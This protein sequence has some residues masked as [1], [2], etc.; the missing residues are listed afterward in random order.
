MSFPLL[1]VLIA[2]APNLILVLFGPQWHGAVLP[3][4][5]LC[6]AGAFKVLNTY[7]SSA[8]QAAGRVWSEVWRQIGY[9]VLI[10]SGV[11][12]FRSWGPSGA[13]FG[14]LLATF[15]MSIMMHV[16]LRR[17]T[18]LRLA[19]LSR[20]LTPS[21]A[22]AMSVV[23]V[24]LVV[25]AGFRRLT[26][27]PNPWVVVLCQAVLALVSY[28]AFLLFVPSAPV[29]ALVHDVVSDM[30]PPALRERTWLRLYLQSPPPSAPVA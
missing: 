10:A 17:V 2:T 15:M 8:T 19:Q 11:Y 21:V 4:Q 7:A 6:V 20:A 29:R 27:D 16:L 30:V 1:A 24:V 14:V 23:V 28:A 25:Q 5:I 12:L 22:C 18:G 3:F 13:A 9:T 26:G